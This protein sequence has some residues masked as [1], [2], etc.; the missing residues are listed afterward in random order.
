MV[1]STPI[2]ATRGPCGVNLNMATGLGG[3]T[4][5]PGDC[6]ICITC[7][8]ILLFDDNLLLHRASK[9]EIETIPD[10]IKACYAKYIAF[11]KTHPL[12]N[13]RTMKH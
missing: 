1:R 4:P 6:T 7:D 8:T 10:E 11:K 2:P 9:E 12:P 5:S 13:T 3:A